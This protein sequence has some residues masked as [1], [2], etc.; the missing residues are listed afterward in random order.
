MTQVLAEPDSQLRIF[1]KPEVHGKRRMAVT[2]SRG[3]SIEEARQKAVTAAQNI[4]L[5]L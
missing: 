3:K 2:L 4:K 5:T 1:G